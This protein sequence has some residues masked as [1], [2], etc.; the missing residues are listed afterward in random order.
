[1]QV[2]HKKEQLKNPQSLRAWIGKIAENQIKAYFLKKSKEEELLAPEV[3]KV[4]RPVFDSISSKE[5]EIEK[6][7]I[8]Q[9]QC[10]LLVEAMKKLSLEEQLLIHLRNYEDKSFSEI[11]KIMDMN[12]HTA[13]TKNVGLLKNAKRYT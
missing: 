10:D 7:L 12:L 6:Q 3:D 8:R 13:K 9:E 1:M 2:L 11:A 5:E 4:G